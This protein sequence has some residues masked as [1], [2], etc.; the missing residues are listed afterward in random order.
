[1]NLIE[2]IELKYPRLIK[3][4]ENQGIEKSTSK[5][6]DILESTDN[7]M[8][9]YTKIYSDFTYESF[10]NES[11]EM[12]RYYRF[13][14]ARNRN[15][16]N[17]EE[18]DIDLEEAEV[19]EFYAKEI[20]E[21]VHFIY[22]ISEISEVFIAYILNFILGSDN[23]VYLSNLYQY[24]FIRLGRSPYY[25]DEE[26][27]EATT[28]EDLIIELFKRSF[29]TLKMKSREERSYKFFK[30]LKNSY[31]FDFMCKFDIALTTQTKENN[32]LFMESD[33]SLASY[34]EKKSLEIVP[35]SIY[36]SNLI[37]HFKKAMSSEDISTQYLSFYHIVEYYFDSLYNEDIVAKMR[38]WLIDPQIS[39]DDD[40]SILKFVDKA[41][42][43]KGQSSEDGQ[44]NEFDAF[45][46]VLVKFIDL[47]KLKMKL[48]DLTRERMKKEYQVKIDE[49]NML[50]FY[51][52]NSVKFLGDNLNINFSDDN[53][54]L[55]NIRN[56]VYNTRNSLVHSKDSYTLKT[57]HPYDDEEALRKEIPLIKTIAIEII[58]NSSQRINN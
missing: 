5:L 41:K 45:L 10:I 55:K 8:L 31:L 13:Y 43:I 53:A 29:R 40:S 36:E 3:R 49:P 1:M 39:L 2:K 22:E 16:H 51:G 57:Y 17:V 30:E 15:I 44:G 6:D 50:D 42:K 25:R 58:V 21:N 27:E 33:R 20:P 7:Y 28:F 52:R 24:L 19:M 9:K 11:F 35:K 48:R 47:D 37:I 54:A 38:A 18:D 56:R 34:T 26:I 4:L 23:S 46:L 14:N 32:R 12:E